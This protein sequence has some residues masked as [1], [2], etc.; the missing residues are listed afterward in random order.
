V[1]RRVALLATIGVAAT[2]L[3]ASAATAVPPVE[4]S[5]ALVGNGA[6]GE[7]LYGS[8]HAAKLPIASI[9]KIMTALVVLERADPDTVVRVGGPAPTIGG[10]SVGLRAGERISVRDLLTALLVQSGNDAAYALA[11]HVGRSSVSRF[12]SLMNRKAGE[13]G[14]EETHFVRPDGL[15]VRGHHSS[16]RDLFKLARVAMRKPLLREIV[17]LRTATI[18]GGRTLRSWNDLLWSYRGMIGVKTGHTSGAG[19]CQVAAARRNGKTIY[20]ILLGGP[21]RE[22]RNADLVELLD[23]GFSREGASRR[24]TAGPVRLARATGTGVFG[25]RAGWYAGRA[26]DRSGALLRNVPGHF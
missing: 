3:A 16:A 22:V 6:T 26:F 23:W 14:L 11:Y 9:T 25:Q 13:L 20:A 1:W 12:V 10:S 18:T 7:I 17:R 2:A 4:A 24:A 8:R 5:A 19:W 15:D 21:S